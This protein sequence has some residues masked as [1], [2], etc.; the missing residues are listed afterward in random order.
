MAYEIMVGG[1]QHGGDPSCEWCH[2]TGDI[3]DP[4][5]VDMVAAAG[6][7]QC[8]YCGRLWSSDEA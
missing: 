6:E 1:E 4:D 2:G 5:D 8:A 3:P 7:T